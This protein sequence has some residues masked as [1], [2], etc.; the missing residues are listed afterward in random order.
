MNSYDM[1]NKIHVSFDEKI[2]PE[3]AKRAFS[4]IRRVDT[5]LVY[6]CLWSKSQ[7]IDK[8]EQI[9]KVDF[10]HKSTG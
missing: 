8:Y 10:W 1:I 5:I 9:I 7:V 4:L 3:H 6:R 2:Y